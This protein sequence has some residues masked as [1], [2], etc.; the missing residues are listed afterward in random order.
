[1]YNNK[2]YVMYMINKDDVKS[3]PYDINKH[4]IIKSM[5]PFKLQCFW[6]SLF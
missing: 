2:Q 5:S 6:T 4:K 3:L 1:M